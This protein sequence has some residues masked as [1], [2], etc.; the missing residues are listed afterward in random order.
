MDGE[1]QLFSAGVVGGIAVACIICT[2]VLCLIVHCIIGRLRQNKGQFNVNMSVIVLRQ[3]KGRLF[4]FLH[5]N[6]VKVSTLG[7]IILKNI[8]N[9]H[10]KLRILMKMI[11][12]D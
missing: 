3:I 7:K 8:Y 10:Y 4:N 1:K 6:I 5:H 9:A 12:T 2:S 11:K